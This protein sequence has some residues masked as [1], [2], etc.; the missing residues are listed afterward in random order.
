[1]NNSSLHSLA[2]ITKKREAIEIATES[3]VMNYLEG[4]YERNDSEFLYHT[5][6][7]LNQLVVELKRE[8]VEAA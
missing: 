2:Q 7:S 5:I 3:F 1:M 4:L 6:E 8:R